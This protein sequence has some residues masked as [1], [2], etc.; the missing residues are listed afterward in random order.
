[1]LQSQLCPAV[2]ALQAGPRS[3]SAKTLADSNVV[4]SPQAG[5][6]RATEEY[7]LSH[8]FGGSNEGLSASLRAP[9]SGLPP[10]IGMTRQGCVPFEHKDR[11]YD[12]I[13]QSIVLNWGMFMARSVEERR[14][15]ILEIVAREGE[16]VVLDLV[17]RFRVSSVT[18]RR[19]VEALTARGMVRRTHGSVAPVRD[20]DAYTHEGPFTI[21]MVV[22]HSNYYFDAIISGATAAAAA[23]GVRLVLGVSDY[24]QSTEI[25]QVARLV[26]KGVNGL[27]VAPTPDF[28]TGELDVDQQEWLV[29]LPVPVVLVERPIA[30]SGPASVLD[31]VSSSHTAGVALAVRHLAELGHQKIVCVAIS[32]PNTPRI[33]DGYLAAVESTGLTSMGVISEGTPN[34]TEAASALIQVVEDGATAVFVHND[35]LA[36]KCLMWLEDA[37]IDVPGDVSLVGYDDVIAAVANI[38]LTAVAPWKKEVGRR[39]VHQ[40]LNRLRRGSL[41]AASA[42]E[43]S[44]EIAAEHVELVPKLHV[45]QSTTPPR[46]GD[47]VDS[48]ASSQVVTEEV[49]EATAG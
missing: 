41:G 5:T 6:A 35:Q 13:D 33:V 22:P 30:A 2:S 17:K 39:A 12:R 9:H 20:A 29:S 1:M 48:A 43:S 28:T 4:Y 10:S 36:V 21:G 15:A 18:I 24:N 3:F 49:A 16:Q 46:E 37:G 19:D 40:L 25:S 32:A 34:S 38:Q 23:A 45:R 47:A 26:S 11:T 31:S 7:W 44:Q 27:I 14:E 42:R 8:S